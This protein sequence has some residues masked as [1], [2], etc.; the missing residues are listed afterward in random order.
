[1]RSPGHRAS[2]ADVPDLPHDPAQERVGL[3]VHDPGATRRMTVRVMYRRRF[4]LTSLGAFATSLRAEAQQAGKAYRLGLLGTVPLTNQGA[5]RIWGGFFEGL[6]Q[7]GYVEGR[8]IVIEGRYS[9][10]RF[11]RLPGFVAELVRLKVDVIVAA[12]TTTAAAKSVTSTIP[13]VMTNEADPVGRGLVTSLAKPGGNVTGLTGRVTD[14][15]G[16]RLQLLKEAMPQLSRLAV[17]ANPLDP[18]HRSAL[19]EAQVVARTLKLRLEIVEARYPTEIAGA[20][21]AATKGEAGA[22]LVLGGPMLF[23]EHARIV[24][25]ATQGRVPVYG[26][27]REYAEAGGLLTYGIDQRDNFRRAATYVDKILKG[28]KPAD[29]PVEQPTKFELVVNLKTAKA[30][31]LTIPPSVL[32]RADQVIE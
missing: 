16:K 18:D 27:Q 32:V 2:L 28:A 12:T 17:L 24:D 6:Q 25:L 22:L 9:E 29:L 13:I 30:L 4:L 19:Q 21:S 11:E 8:N 14:L 5:A 20:V 1:M 26:P 10:G 7:L 3:H 15:V 31:G 23:A